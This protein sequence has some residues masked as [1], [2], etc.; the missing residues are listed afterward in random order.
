MFAYHCYIYVSALHTKATDLPPWI[1]AAPKPYFVTS[2]CI[3]TGQMT[4]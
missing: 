4:S 3:V 2:T 1:S